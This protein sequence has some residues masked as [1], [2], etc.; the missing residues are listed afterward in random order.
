MGPPPRPTQDTNCAAAAASVIQV[1]AAAPP[2]ANGQGD[3][4]GRWDDSQTGVKRALRSPESIGADS[5]PETGNAYVQQTV[6]PT[7]SDDSQVFV[8]QPS[9]LP[10]LLAGGKSNGHSTQ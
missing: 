9:L 2:H 10:E 6:S 7:V 3:S 1:L 4:P 8:R 5:I